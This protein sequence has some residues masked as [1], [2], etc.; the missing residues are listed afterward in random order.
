MMEQTLRT[1]TL[2][3]ARASTIR[4]LF[5]LFV[6]LGG[7]ALATGVLYYSFTAHLWFI[8]APMCLVSGLFMVKLFGLFHDCTHGSMFNSPTLNIWVG[9]TLSL[10]ITM[11][12][13]SW[14]AEHDDHHSHVVDMEK[15]HHGDIPLMTVEQYRNASPLGRTVYRVFRQPLVFLITAP[16]LYFFV[17]SRIPAIWTK[18]VVL[19]VAITNVVV[20]IIYIP[21][22]LHFGFWIMAFVFAPA[23]YF[24]G[25]IG[26]ALF[27][28]QHNYP[29]TEWFATDDW[30]FE[31]ASLAGS[32]LLVL[33]APLEWF[34][35]AIGFHHIHHLNSKIPGYRLRECYESV[36][37]MRA[38][39][40]LTWSE[41]REAFKLHI[42]SYQAKQLVAVRDIENLER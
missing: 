34:S 40:P 29:E 42:W 39:R 21:L 2:T 8:F 26:V 10:F 3:F 35:H 13:T 16:F 20:G 11:P 9:R 1:Q 12:F 14:K 37:E 41:M 32:S 19:S 6:T 17:K 28:L 38:V 30:H 7:Y 36:S 15:M 33:P 24:G 4:S 22:L 5:E 27:Y 31:T 18:E 25:M 23:A